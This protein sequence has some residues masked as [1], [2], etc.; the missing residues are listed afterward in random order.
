[1][2][3]VLLSSIAM[4]R[5]SAREIASERNTGEISPETVP[6]QNPTKTCRS[7]FGPVDHEE[8]RRELTSKLKEIAE[9][10]RQR[11]N[12]DF[13]EGRP[14]D[15]ELEWEESPAEDCPIFYREKITTTVP[16][17]PKRERLAPYCGDRFTSVNVLNETDRR[18][19]KKSRKTAAHA[20]TKRLTDLRITDF[21][22]KRRKTGSMKPKG[23]RNVE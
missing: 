14:L 11:W 7:L 12:F 4:A 16:A 5:L 22:G 19:P 23:I 20:Q 2:S 10:D 17:R 8:L 1:M 3:A 15:G 21:Y 18:N 6:L 9:H 13:G